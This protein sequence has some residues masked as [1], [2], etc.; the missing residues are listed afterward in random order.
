MRWAAH[1]AQGAQS[2]GTRTADLEAPCS[3]HLGLKPEGKGVGG[4]CLLKEKSENIVITRTIS[5]ITRIK[6]SLASQYKTAACRDD[7]KHRVPGY[8]A[9]LCAGC[10]MAGPHKRTHKRRLRREAPVR[11]VCFF[12]CSRWG[13]ELSLAHTLDPF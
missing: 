10:R 4:F 3:P 13:P 5:I 12:I 1:L 6:M 2:Q 9:T 8:T 11:V 7:Q